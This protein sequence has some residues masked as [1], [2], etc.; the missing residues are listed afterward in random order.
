MKRNE[1]LSRW[2]EDDYHFYLSFLSEFNAKY[3]KVG[4]IDDVK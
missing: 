1:N 4:I 3:K 2:R